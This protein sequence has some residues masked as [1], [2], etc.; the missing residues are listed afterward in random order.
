MHI[1]SMIYCQCQKTE[2]KV[3]NPHLKDGDV[4]RNNVSLS[5]QMRQFY[6]SAKAFHV[7]E[8]LD[9]NPEYWEGK[10]GAC[11]GVFQMIIAGREAK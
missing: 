4:V 8:S 6:Y 2:L 11:V 1:P 3:F 5:V 10:R 7:L 9:S